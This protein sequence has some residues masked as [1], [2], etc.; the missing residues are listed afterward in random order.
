MDKI[1]VIVPCFNEEDVLPLF[2]KEV[3]HVL[4]S[5][6]NIDYEIL[7]MN[8]GSHDHSEDILKLLA[9]KNLIV[10]IILFLVILEK[11]PL[12]MQDL[13]ML[14]EIMLLLWMQIYNI[15]LIY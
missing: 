7:F 5:I 14:V 9:H 13:K 2:Y 3:A 12:C 4:E 10:S 8:D 6:E 1:S 11:K 15:L